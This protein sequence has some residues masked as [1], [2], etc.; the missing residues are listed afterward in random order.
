MQRQGRG[1]SSV[2]GGVLSVREALGAVPVLGEWKELCP[3]VQSFHSP[4]GQE[5]VGFCGSSVYPL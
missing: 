1:C 3:K 4:L 2:M 5:V